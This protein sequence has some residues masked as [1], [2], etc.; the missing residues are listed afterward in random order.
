MGKTAFIIV[1]AVHVRYGF[2][3]ELN[4]AFFCTTYFEDI[5]NNLLMVCRGPVNIQM[6]LSFTLC[7]V[8]A[9][10]S[11]QCIPEI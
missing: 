8:T 6:L 7:M 4:H 1:C 3:Q 2:Q 10:Q 9:I 5:N 11:Q